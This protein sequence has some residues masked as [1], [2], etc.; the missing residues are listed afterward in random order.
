VVHPFEVGHP[1]GWGVWIWLGQLG[2]VCPISG[3][4]VV[5]S[6]LILDHL[7]TSLIGLSMRGLALRGKQPN[8][9]ALHVALP[10]LVRVIPGEAE[11]PE[12]GQHLGG[13]EETVLP[14]AVLGTVGHVPFHKGSQMRVLPAH[15]F[16]LGPEVREGLQGYVVPGAR[17][18]RYS[19]DSGQDVI[20]V[21]LA[22][23]C[24]PIRV[25]PESNIKQVGQ[26]VH[27]VH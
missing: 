9:H 1:V 8:W 2:A 23:R 5:C 4:V 15:S 19:T 24:L 13:E 21:G 7:L 17:V 22:G 20:L 10:P 11:V 6:V 3:T 27:A 14:G 16:D 12:S 18:P 25:V 26:L